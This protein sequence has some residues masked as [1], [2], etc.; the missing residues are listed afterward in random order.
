MKNL[1]KYILSVFGLLSLIIVG[2]CN[3]ESG[4]YSISGNINVKDGLKVYRVIADVNN[5][6]KIVD[7][8]T[9]IKN[10]F[11]MKGLA[12]NPS[13]SFLQVETYRFNLPV[14]IEEGDIKVKIF[15]DSIGSSKIYGTTSN[16]HFNDYKIETK[17]FVEAIDEIRS[18]IQQAA[19]NGNNNLTKDLQ[20]D[21]TTVQDQIHKY[22]IEFLK[23]NLDS[24]LSIILLQRFVVNKKVLSAGEVKEIFNSFTERI[25]N[26]DI[27]I[28]LKLLIE[29]P[30]QPIEVGSFAPDFSAPTPDGQLLN[31]NDKLGKVTLIEFWASWCGPCRRENPNLVKIY[32]NFKDKGFEIIGVS[33]DKSKAQWTRAISDDYLTWHHVS[34]LKF[35]Q[36]PLAK[37]YKV[38]AIPVSFILD[39]K[40]KI[41]AK[42]LRGS[43]LESKVSELLSNN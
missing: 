22:E 30:N 32:K 27:G 43:Q 29:N 38:S 41:I 36:D 24:Y 17:D 1:I 33:L 11:S 13:I 9:I 8:T 21:Y 12:N 10:K 19:Q 15:K 3:S 39:E 35:W 4:S 26:S 37:L 2:S 20:N 6:P 16:D 14:V 23:R 40:G 31:L 5:Q 42:N 34:N 25:Q 28:K 7:S 18:E